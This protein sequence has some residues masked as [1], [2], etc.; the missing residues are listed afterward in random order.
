MTRIFAKFKKVTEV[1][2]L[3]RRQ[4]RLE[5]TLILVVV[6]GFEQQA[7]IGKEFS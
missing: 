2:G 6:D 1:K 7:V 4:V 5:D 3:K